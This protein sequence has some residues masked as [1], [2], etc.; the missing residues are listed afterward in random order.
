MTTEGVAAMN[1]ALRDPLNPPGPGEPLAPPAPVR[2]GF[3][4]EWRNPDAQA[5]VYKEMTASSMENGWL[6]IGDLEGQEV[7]INLD[8][9]RQVKSWIEP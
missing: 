3:V 2:R 1:A 4:I 5:A 8:Q 7:W 9:V 6:F